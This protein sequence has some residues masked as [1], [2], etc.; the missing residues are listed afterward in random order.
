[1]RKNFLRTLLAVLLICSMMSTTAYADS[2]AVSGNNVNLRSGPGVK[3]RVLDTLPKGTVVEITDRSNT[4]WFGVTYNGVSGYISTGYLEPISNSDGTA[5]VVQDPSGGSSG[6]TA[7]IVGG[8]PSS[9]STTVVTPTATPTPKPSATP[10]ATPKPNADGSNNATLVIGSGKSTT[11][12]AADSTP[13]PA[14]TPKPTA[15]PAPATSSATVSTGAKTGT[16][17]GDYV[18]FRSGPSTSNS[19]IAS[20][21][22]GKEVTITGTQGEWTACTIDGKSGYVFSQ[23][24]TANTASGSGG[25]GAGSTATATLDLSPSADG[26]KE[27]KTETE[28]ATTTVK[29]GEKT[30]TPGYITGNNV[31]F[32][33]GASMSSGILGELFYGNVVTITGTQ[34]EWTAITY[35]GKA[36]YVYSTYVTAGS[37]STKTTTIGGSSAGSATG[38]QIADYALGYV[39][40][41][42]AWGGKSPETGFDCSGFTYY[43]F[44]QFGYTINRVAADQAKNGRAVDAS[45]LQV[46]DLI[47][48]YSGSNYIGHVGIY[49]GN[50]QFVHAA[51]SSTGVIISDLAG[52]YVSRGYEVRRIV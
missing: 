24:V 17:N 46:G 11:T 51:T 7:V 35:E 52:Y 9:G 1:M 13:V 29:S 28:T 10:T 30:G 25:S 26:K 3:Y 36:G 37:M 27:S 41:R 5:T 16:I 15:T 47:L 14:A 33:S 22:K 43:V 34:G 45:D 2:A 48:F 19:I 50:N 8:G 44:G 12:P 4:S 20:Y 39:G 38:K 49:I 18:R 42:Y 32:R 23:Y 40:Y 21:N 6:E 31:R